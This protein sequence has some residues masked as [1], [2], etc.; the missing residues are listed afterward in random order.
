GVEGDVGHPARRVARILTH[1]DLPTRNRL[2]GA[3]TT[4][5][6]RPYRLALP[7]RGRGIQ[8]GAAHGHHVG[9][10]GRPT[11]RGAFRTAA[12]FVGARV[13]RGHRERLALRTGLLEDRSG[14]RGRTVPL[15][16]GFAFAQRHV[17]D[18]GEGGRF[19]RGRR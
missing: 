19:G 17:D 8:R 10:T 6:T 14:G 7:I 18:L 13:A 15:R 1:P 9:R 16:P 11:R 3:G 12:A 5:R 4:A 2:E